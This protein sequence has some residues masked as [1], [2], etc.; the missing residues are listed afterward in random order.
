MKKLLLLSTAV[1]LG[2]SVFAQQS[3]TAVNHAIPQAAPALQV[4]VPKAP[5]VTGEEIAPA[6]KAKAVAADKIPLAAAPTETLIGVSTYDLQTNSS[7]QNRIKNHGNGSISAVWTYSESLDL[8]AND[9]GTGYN[10]FD[11]STWGPVPTSRVEMVRVGWPSMVANPTLGEASIAHTVNEDINVTQRGTVGSGTWSEAIIPGPKTLWAR[12][13]SNGNS[14]HS[15]SITTPVA[16]GGTIYQQQDGA[17]TYS[18]STDGGASWGIQKVVPAGTDFNFSEGY[19]GDGYAIAEPRGD[20]IAFAMFD[21]WQDGY[22]LKSTDDGN[23]WTKTIFNDFPLDLYDGTLSDVDG[24]N[25]A[26]TIDTSDD[27]GTIVLDKNGMAHIFYGAMRVLDDDPADGGGSFFPAT[28]GLMYWNEDFGTNPPVMISG[29]VD[30]NGDG[31]IGI[32]GNAIA[33]IADYFLSLSGQPSAGVAANGDLYVVFSGFMENLDQGAQNYRHMHAIR[34]QDGGCSWTQPLDLNSTE[35]FAECVFGS[36]ARDVD[37]NLHIVYQKDDEPGLSVRGDEDPYRENEIMYM[38]VPTTDFDTLAYEFCNVSLV[39]DSILCIGD[40]LLLR[41]SCGSAYQWLKD[42]VPMTGET[43][44]V[45]WAL[46]TAEYSV[47]ITTPC[48]VVPLTASIKVSPLTVLPTFDITA[49][50]DQ[51][52]NG[53]PTTLQVSNVL[54]GAANFVWSTGDSTSVV[55]V[56]SVGTYTVNVNNCGG[57]GVDSITIS[58]PNLPVASVTGPDEICPGDSIMLEAGAEP[59]ASYAWSTGDSTQ[60]AVIDTVGVYTVSVTNCAGT[61]STDYTVGAVAPPSA[62]VN[63]TGN[64]EFCEGSGESVTLAALSGASWE[65]TGGATSQSITLSTANQSGSYACTVSNACGATTASAATTITINPAPAQPTITQSALV[66]TCN[67]TADSYQWYINGIAVGGETGQT[68][69]A[70]T[71]AQIDGREVTVVAIDANDCESAASAEIT[72]LSQLKASGTTGFEVFP[73]PNDGQF[74]IAFVNFVADAYSI[75]VRNVLGQQVFHET[76]NVSG[77]QNVAIN[78]ANFDKGMYF[79]TVSNSTSEYTKR[80]VVK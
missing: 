33:G 23:T 13:A 19:G 34:S 57:T 62:F 46:D 2:L 20:T 10:F 72:G 8:T 40:S 30:W 21:Q 76:H 50:A 45:L 64:A 1:G 36:L 52:C 6:N 61:A 78:M 15:F 65:W 4:A 25:V 53:D 16:N 28:N 18:R 31:V 73:N 24:D 38:N 80:V 41:A 26:D 37:N 43:S 49:T 32:V 11:G 59:S 51:I 7:I 69:T 35:F 75:K 22:M 44:E 63:Q 14:I 5:V 47:E 79:V 77:D 74:S 54:G 9:R 17:L 66:F 68:F 48:D 67:E 58:L 3:S 29:A 27:A 42:G 71:W 39:G 55:T 60:I 56:D 70:D 12:S